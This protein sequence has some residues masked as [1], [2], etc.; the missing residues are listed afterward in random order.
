MA[1]DPAT[2]TPIFLGF[3]GAQ[4][5][6]GVSAPRLALGLSRGLSEYASTSL[7]VISVDVGTLGVGAGTGSGMVMPQPAA[8]ASMVA[9]FQSH[10]ISGISSVPCAT[11][12]ALGMCSSLMQSTIQTVSPS[13]GTGTG[14]ATLLPS[15]ESIG[16]FI[17]SFQSSGLQGVQSANMATA[18]AQGFN[19]VAPLC[20]AP[21]AIVGPPN[22]SPSSGSGL[23]K[24][25]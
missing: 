11:A 2:T 22:V 17:R 3:L 16:I 10:S 19:A 6:L 14:I 7:R 15:A 12:I 8:V 25:Y 18:V 9:A 24:L 5:N 13:V 4:G 1:L 23:G 20:K 21:I